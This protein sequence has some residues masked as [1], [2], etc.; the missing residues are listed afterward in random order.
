M[1]FNLTPNG[2]QQQQSNDPIVQVRTADGRVV[3]MR[4]SQYLFLLK[5]QQMMNKR[6]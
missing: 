6:R 4:Y 1:V 3:Q 2:N 5:Q